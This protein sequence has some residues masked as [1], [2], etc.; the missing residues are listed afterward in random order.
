MNIKYLIIVIMVLTGLKTMAHCEIPCGIYNDKARFDSMLEHSTTIYK[1]MSAI[2]ELTEASTVNYHDIARWTM[3]KE[4]H[5]SKIQ[6][7]ATQY[8]LTQRVKPSTESYYEHLELLHKII[9]TAM[10]TKQSIDTEEAHK[11]H[12]L[13]QE[14]Q[15]KY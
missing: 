4:K 3:N 9:I 2:N 6:K 13:I 5:A 14:Y 11:L 8:F 10:K 1:S 7:I 12:H 15:E